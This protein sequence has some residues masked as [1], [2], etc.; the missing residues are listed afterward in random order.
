MTR[1]APPFLVL[2]L[3]RSRTAW[4][5]RFLT[6]GEYHCAHEQLRHLRSVDDARAWLAQDFTGTAETGAAPWWRLIRHLRP[7]VRVLIVRRPVAE[8]VASVLALDLSGL[9]TTSITGLMRDM[10]RLDRCLDRIERRVPG[11]LSVRYA[12]L[13]SE[14]TCAAVFEHCL[15]YRHDPSWWSRWASVNVQTDMRMLMRHL[16]AHGPQMMRLAADGRRRTLTL[17]RKQYPLRPEGD[18]D[19]LVIAEERF[20]DFWR[21]GQ[22]LFAEHAAE[23]GGREGVTLNPNVPLILKLEELGMTQILTARSNGR[24]FGYL[25]TIIAPSLEDAS[26]TVGHQNTFYVSPDFRG[27]GAR[28]QRASIDLL[29]AKGLNELTMRAGVRGSGPRMVALYRRL[30]AEPY[31]ELFNL[32]LKAA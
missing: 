31:G 6:Y 7:D 1:V 8:V 4:L 14:A 12:D 26:A 18:A 32:N 15:P 2:G 19:G 3:P 20:E 30:G 9:V 22:R 29:K 17:L 13:A 24:L 11:V 21:D 27:A 10:Q 23:V 16:N 28:L 5:A 25:C